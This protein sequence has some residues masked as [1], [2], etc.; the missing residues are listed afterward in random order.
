[1]GAHRIARVLVFW[2]L[3]TSVFL[4]LLFHLFGAPLNPSRGN[5]MKRFYEEITL[6]NVLA[7][8]FLVFLVVDATLFLGLFVWRLSHS[9]T[10]WPGQVR[11]KFANKLNLYDRLNVGENKILD[12]WID[13]QFIA[14]RTKC[15]N[16]LV[17]YPFAILSLMIVSR[18]ALFANFPL[19]PPIAIAQGAGL[20][21]IF[22]C[23]F[24]LNWFAEDQ[25]KSAQ[26]NLREEI[27]RARNQGD[28]ARE[29]RWQG[30]LDRVT[31]LHEGSF[32]NFLQQP[33]VAGMLLPLGSLGWTQLLERGQLF[34][35]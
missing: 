10:T 22:A 27:T 32:R 28:D 8:W 6:L 20:F 4:G 12:D 21:L 26:R 34:G 19:S 14:E 18:S 23:A 13:L 15:I 31:D 11:L 9:Q 35:L 3:T 30:L 7:M 17:W 24:T 25:R 5:L 2:G 1:M 29:K 16:S 33:V